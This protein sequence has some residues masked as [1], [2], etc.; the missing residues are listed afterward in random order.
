MSAFDP[1][2][3]LE[4]CRQHEEPTAEFSM[5]KAHPFPEVYFD[6]NARMLERG[7]SLV[8]GSVEDLARLG[9]SPANAVGM[10]F[11]FVMHDT[12]EHGNSDDIMFNGIVIHDP[13]WGFLAFADEDG[14][15]MRSE[16]ETSGQ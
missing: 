7:Y 3:T 14:L 10:R 15:Y 12:D 2:R 16:I 9:L 11:T 6:G 8:R 5:R 4:R 13:K 1:K